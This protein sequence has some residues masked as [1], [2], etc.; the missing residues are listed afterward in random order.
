MFI[1]PFCPGRFCRHHFGPQVQNWF[2]KR[3]TYSTEAFGTVHRFRCRDCGAGFSEQTFRL[4]YYVKKPISY[5]AVFERIIAGCGIRS[6]GRHLHISHQAIINRTSRLARQALAIHAALLDDLSLRED[7]ATDGFES[8]VGSQYHPNNIHLLV[9]CDSQLLYSFDYAHLRRKGRMSDYQRSRREQIETTL[10]YPRVTIEQSFAHIA[11]DV[12]ALLEQSDRPLTFLHSDEK[13]EYVRVLENKN[14]VPERPELENLAEKLADESL[15]HVRTSSQRR[16]NGANPLFPVNYMDRQIRKDNANHVRETVQFSR[17]V[18]NCLERL[19]CYQLQ[20]N[21]FKPYRIAI[22]GL[23]LFRHSDI[24]GINCA[25]VKR[26]LSSLFELRRFVSRVK[27][28]YSQFIV[29][30]RAVGNLGGNDG[31]YSPKYV[32]M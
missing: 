6:A 4:D 1:P 19:A 15:V 25:A 18:N 29:W 24:A 20:H 31:G 28:S 2:V 26:E 7:L 11:A 13:Q 9:G 21:Y 27:L 5:R 10:I 30:F 22:G 17:Q 3:G 14:V 8:Y 32:W 12:L 16:R 23:S